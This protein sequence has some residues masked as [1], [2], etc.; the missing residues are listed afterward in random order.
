MALPRF[1][2]KWALAFLTLPLHAQTLFLYSSWAMFLLGKH[3]PCF[4]L[5]FTSFLCLDL[6][7]NSL[8]IHPGLLPSLLEHSSG[9]TN[10]ELGESE[11]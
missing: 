3:Y 8:L 4:H 11:S 5:L 10:P 9:W 2:L 7:R 1:N 6:V